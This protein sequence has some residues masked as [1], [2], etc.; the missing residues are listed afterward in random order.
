VHTGEVAVER[1]DRFEKLFGIDVIV[2]HRML[3][4]SV[5]ASEYLMLSAPA[6]EA[7]GDFYMQEP[8]HRTETFDGVGE[9][10]TVVFYE[11]RLARVLASNGEVLP[12]RPSRAAVLSF[13]VRM[14]IKSIGEL[15]TGKANRGARA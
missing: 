10:E 5:P 7:I 4:N 13:D 3:K 15:V 8:E 14:L 2:V 9:V 11:D 1:I 12:E 6:Y